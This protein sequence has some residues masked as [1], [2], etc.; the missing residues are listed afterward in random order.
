MSHSTYSS[1]SERALAPRESFAFAPHPEKIRR[2]LGG[3]ALGIALT[4]WLCERLVGCLVAAPL[5]SPTGVAASPHLA[6][7]IDQVFGCLELAACGGAVLSAAWILLRV[8]PL[9]AA[10]DPRVIVIGK[11]RGRALDQVAWKYQLQRERGRKFLFL[12]LRES[13]RHLKERIDRVIDAQPNRQPW[14]V[15]SFELPARRE[16]RTS[17]QAGRGGQRRSD[18]AWLPLGGRDAEHQRSPAARMP[19]QAS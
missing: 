9:R 13:D 7:G 15:P 3:T 2:A 17:R 14:V 5:A 10:S 8:S 11:L 4:G 12:R 16:A 19:S 1:C 6:S 18:L